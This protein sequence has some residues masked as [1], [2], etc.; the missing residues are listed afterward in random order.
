MLKKLLYIMLI[1]CG[2]LYITSSN[3]EKVFISK[4][5]EVY[6]F[7]SSNLKK[8]DIEVKINGVSKSKK[9]FK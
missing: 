7:C 6:K 4:A 2:Y 3:N 8:M 1:I 5:K 9:L